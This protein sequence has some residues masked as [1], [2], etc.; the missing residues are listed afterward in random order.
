LVIVMPVTMYVDTTNRMPLMIMR[1]FRSE[2]AAAMIL[3]IAA[4]AALIVA[5]SPLGSLYEDTLHTVVLGL[6]IQHWINDA[7]MAVFFLLVGMEIKQEVLTG[8]LASPR[9]R[10]LPAVAALGGMAAPAAIFTAINATSPDHLAGWAIPSATDIAFAMGVLAMLGSRVP[11]A[12]RAL[13]VGIAIID[14]LGAIVIIA[15]FYSEGLNWGWLGGSAIAIAA[16]VAL[17]RRSVY[18]LLPYLAIGA[19]LWICLYQSGIQATLSG[20]V[21][22]FAIPAKATDDLDRSPMK[23]TEHAIDRWVNFGIIPLFGFANAGISF[24]GMDQSAIF[25]SLPIGVALGLFLGKQIG[26]FGATW[27]AIRTGLATHPRGASWAQLYAM[28]V[29]CGIGFT[30]SLF[31]GGLAFGDAP[32]LFDATKVGVIGGSVISAITGSI[33]M[34]RTFLPEREV[35]AF[36]EPSQEVPGHNREMVAR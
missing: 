9:A 3:L 23:T 32:D 8:A 31:I 30:M 12:I 26:V 20:V 16:L 24:S 22:A 13:L 5:N 7:L 28:A 6:S 36:D 11:V 25:G 19:G 1:F 15:L 10:I 33:L 14:D 29:L 18:S 2:T 35:L 17:N 4:V 21:L 34:R 27:L